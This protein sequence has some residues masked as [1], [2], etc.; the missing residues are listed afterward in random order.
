MEAL[1]WGI[2]ITGFFALLAG[3]AELMEWIC[4]E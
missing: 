3:L 2:L 1:L 4:D